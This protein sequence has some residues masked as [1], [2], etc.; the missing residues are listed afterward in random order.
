MPYV[1]GVWKSQEMVAVFDTRRVSQQTIES[2][3]TPYQI[4][5]NPGLAGTSSRSPAYVLAEPYT[6][7][8]RTQHARRLAQI[9]RNPNLVWKP[10]YCGN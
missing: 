5:N 4:W 1:A 6:P 9:D 3:T 7:Q 10:V 2:I 8:Q